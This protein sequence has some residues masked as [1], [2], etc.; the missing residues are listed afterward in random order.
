MN[1]LKQQ[2]HELKTIENALLKIGFKKNS[3]LNNVS[4]SIAWNINHSARPN[5]WGSKPKKNCKAIYT[6]GY[7]KEMISLGFV[8]KEHLTAKAKKLYTRLYTWYEQD[9]KIDD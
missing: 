5:N 3:D 1:T 2:E 8:N 7:E 9:G 6:F 4:Y